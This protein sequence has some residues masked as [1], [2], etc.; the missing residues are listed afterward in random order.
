M[1]QQNKQKIHLQ[2]AIQKNVRKK[3]G[4]WR[5]THE[6]RKKKRGKEVNEGRKNKGKRNETNGTVWQEEGKKVTKK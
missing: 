3:F 5:Q 6:Q 1:K 2:T 4:C